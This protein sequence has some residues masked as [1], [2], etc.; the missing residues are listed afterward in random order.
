MIRHAHRPPRPPHRRTPHPTAHDPST[1]LM[2]CLYRLPA[3]LQLIASSFHISTRLSYNRSVFVQYFIID[4]L[5]PLGHIIFNA[6]LNTMGQLTFNR[7]ALIPY[8]TP[9]KLRIRRSTTMIDEF[10]AH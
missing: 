5:K 6:V 3:N 2:L 1:L 9:T 7:V 4:K 8:S 10:N